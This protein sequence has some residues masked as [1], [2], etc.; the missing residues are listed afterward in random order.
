MNE[1]QIELQTDHVY[2][3]Y[4]LLSGCQQKNYWDILVANIVWTNF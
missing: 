4:I 3:K 1:K 2:L